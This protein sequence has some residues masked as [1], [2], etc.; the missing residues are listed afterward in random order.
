MMQTLFGAF[1]CRLFHMEKET[2]FHSLR[3]IFFPKSQRL[4]SYRWWPKLTTS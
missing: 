3:L 2:S 4:Q 1:I